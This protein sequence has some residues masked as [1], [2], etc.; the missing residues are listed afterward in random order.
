MSKQNEPSHETASAD[1]E[2]AADPELAGAEPKLTPLQRVKQQQAL[3]RQN[4]NNGAHK[5]G[6]GGARGHSGSSHQRAHMNRRSGG[7]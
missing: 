5:P 7:S 6:S 1:P 3:L 2:P 4:R